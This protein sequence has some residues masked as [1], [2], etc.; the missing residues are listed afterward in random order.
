MT[1]AGAQLAI[2][3]VITFADVGSAVYL[4]YI[5]NPEAKTVRIKFQLALLNNFFK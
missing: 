2:F 4:R 3:L 1:Y 5:D